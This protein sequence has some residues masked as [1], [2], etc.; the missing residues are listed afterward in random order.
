MAVPLF[1]ELVDSAPTV[2]T[3]HFHLAF[4]LS[5]VS[6]LQSAIGELRAALECNPPADKRNR[7]QTLLIEL[8]GL[9]K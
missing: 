1:R 4:A 5:G 7:I 9:P 3:Y 2:W 6:G 8:A